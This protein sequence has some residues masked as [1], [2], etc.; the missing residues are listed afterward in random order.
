MS[1]RHERS[2]RLP[3]G[4]KVIFVAR[5]DGVS[6]IIEPEPP[7]GLSKRQRRKLLDAYVVASRDFFDDLAVML[8]GPVV[9]LD[10][11]GMHVSR[12]RTLQ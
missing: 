11:A 7:A 4:A 2:F 12:P 8:G 3:F 5:P 10:E 6:R 1:F 9:T